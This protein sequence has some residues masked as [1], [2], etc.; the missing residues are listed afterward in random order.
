MQTKGT[1][2]SQIY[3]IG[4]VLSCILSFDLNTITKDEQN[5]VLLEWAYS[6]NGIDFSDWKIINAGTYKFRY[7]KFKITLK[8]PNNMPV[9]LTNFI[10]NIDVPDKYLDLELEIKDNNGLQIDYSF[11]KPPSIVATVNDN[12][13]AY[14]VIT[15]KTNTYAILKAYTNT[16]EKTS[17]KV[18]LHAKGY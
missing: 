8:S 16:G 1:Y 4:A 9:V 12:T 15:E 7:C 6:D 5:T 17:C 11:I 2:T 18:S 13:S 14:V 3:D 10:I